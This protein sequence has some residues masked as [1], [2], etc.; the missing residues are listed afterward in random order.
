MHRDIVT[1]RMPPAPLATHHA[2]I[3][4]R[5]A[6]VTRLLL[7]PGDLVCDAVGIA[8]SSDHRQIL[9]MFLN[10]MIWSAVAIGFTLWAT[11]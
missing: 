8:E 6:P 10:T 9:R 7:L 2:P 5:E 4:P 11:L 3:S 1:D